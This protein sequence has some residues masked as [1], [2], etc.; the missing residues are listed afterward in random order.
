MDFILENIASTAIILLAGIKVLV[1]LT[2]TEN[3]NKV[4]GRLDAMIDGLVPDRKKKA[5]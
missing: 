4:F 2:P 1:N 3:D 5:E